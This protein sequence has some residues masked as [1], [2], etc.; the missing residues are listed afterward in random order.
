MPCCNHS[1]SASAVRGSTSVTIA[2]ETSAT[3]RGFE[4]DHPLAED[5]RRKSFTIST[6]FT[7][8]QACAPDF[9]D[10]YAQACKKAAPLMRFVSDAV[11]VEW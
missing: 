1:P 5:F 6:R 8:Q 3:T 11:G 9:L 4:P 7:Q 2:T 10:R